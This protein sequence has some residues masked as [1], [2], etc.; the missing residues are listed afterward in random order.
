MKSIFFLVSGMEQYADA[1]DYHMNFFETHGAFSTA[2]II[3]AIVAL[4]LAAIYYFGFCMSRKTIGMA[5]VP[6]WI[7]CLLLTGVLTFTTTSLVLIGSDS[8]DGDETALTYQHSFYRNM[9]DYYIEI[10]EDAPATEQEQMMNEKNDIVD[11][12]NMGEDVAL[13]FN[14]NST[15]Y[16]IIFFYIFSLLMKGFTTNGLAIPHL[17][18]HGR[19]RK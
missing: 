17:W 13:M 16:A 11:R 8:E 9:E 6:V 10:S 14:I 19:S 7:V 1:Y 18:P 4:L 15:I 3:A 12:L 5:N 2:F